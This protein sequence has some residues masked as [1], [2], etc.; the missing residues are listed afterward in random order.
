MTAR[1]GHG[2]ATT[3]EPAMVA[4]RR[5]RDLGPPPSRSARDAA[6]AIY[7]LRAPNLVQHAAPV[8]APLYRSGQQLRPVARLSLARA[9]PHIIPRSTHRPRAADSIAA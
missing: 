3:S 8:A 5:V 9:V 1:A 7:R 2:V 6:G 4:L